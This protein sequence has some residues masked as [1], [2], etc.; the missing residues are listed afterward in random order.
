MWLQDI[1]LEA[2]RILGESAIFILA[3]FAIAGLLHVYLRE[4]RLLRHLRGLG[5]RSVLLGSIVGS[6]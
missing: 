5:S 2:W 1:L 4:G 6:V 3:G